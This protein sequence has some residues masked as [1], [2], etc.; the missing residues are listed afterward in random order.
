MPELLVGDFYR[1]T[2]AKRG[3]S[4]GYAA[5]SQGTALANGSASD[6][7]SIDS[8]RLADMTRASLGTQEWQ[9]GGRP[10]GYRSFGRRR[11][12]SIK[13]TCD[14]IDRA[15]ATAIAGTTPDTTSNS[16]YPQYSTDTAVFNAPDMLGILTQEAMVRGDTQTKYFHW[17]FPF[18]RGDVTITNLSYQQKVSIEFNFD[19]P[20]DVGRNIFGQLFPAAMGLPDD[21]LIGHHFMESDY[22]IGLLGYRGDGTETTFTPQYLPI[23]NE[24]T[25]GAAYNWNFVNGSAVAPTSISTTTGDMVLS[26]A[27]AAGVWGVLLY[28]TRFRPSA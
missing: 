5:G 12:N 7:W 4:A 23:S 24:V 13:V 8:C 19:I 16:R 10:I 25:L 9:G 3:S 6:A 20:A 28:G 17:M 2:L 27:P 18:L 21:G 1:F 15:V 14:A 22:P 11:I 26:S